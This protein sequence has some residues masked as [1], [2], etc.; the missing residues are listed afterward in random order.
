MAEWIKLFST[1][2]LA[3]FCSMS[4]RKVFHTRDA[5]KVMKKMKRTANTEKCFNDALCVYLPQMMLYLWRQSN[6]RS[7]STKERLSVYAERYDKMLQQVPHINL[8]ERSQNKNK[9]SGCSWRREFKAARVGKQEIVDWGGKLSLWMGE[10]LFENLWLG[11]A[12]LRYAA[13]LH[14]IKRDPCNKLALI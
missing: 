12:L 8:S 6:V 2:D 9:S 11:T 14:L 13:T 7:E 3:A 4:K 1:F 5:R 10:S